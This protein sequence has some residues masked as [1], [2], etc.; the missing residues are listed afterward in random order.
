MSFRLRRRV[1]DETRCGWLATVGPEVPDP[2]APPLEGTVKADYVVI[3]AGFTGL[4]A[5]A[6]LAELRPQDSI[7]L[8]DAVPLGAGPAG[9]SSGFVVDLAYFIAEMPAAIGDAFVDLSRFGID[10]LRRRVEE[11]QLPC[12]W[13]ESGWVHVAG[14][15][16]GERQMK[17]LASW[18]EGRG[19]RFQALGSEAMRELCGSSYYRGGLRLPGSVLVQPAALVRSLASALPSNV[20]LATG[21]AVR[22]IHPGSAV[23]LETS[24]AS[25]EAPQVVLAVNSLLP[26]LGVLRQRV[27]PLHTF[28]SFTRPLTAEEADAIGGAKEW[29]LLAQDP[30]GSSVRRT[31]EDRILIRNLAHFDRR[32]TA[33]QRMQRRAVASHRRALIRRFPELAEVA[34]EHSWDGLLGMT[35]NHRHFFGAIDVGLWATG[36]YFGAGIVMGTVSGHLLA[37]EIAGNGAET[38]RLSL[39]RTIIGPQWLP[40]TPV[41]D[42]G[43]SLRVKQLTWSVDDQV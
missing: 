22:A 43:V 27:F 28:G 25:I 37:E 31:R 3:G 1:R 4:A 6:R 30:M 24:R 10:Q 5:A 19:E 29:G 36:G 14:T 7:L 9:R 33:P 40:P 42:W 16:A 15:D 13:D 34:F 12:Q 18:L 2:P 41:L 38:H 35:G 11:H 20:R 32:P 26:N 21:D 23:R 17:R 39:L 8:L